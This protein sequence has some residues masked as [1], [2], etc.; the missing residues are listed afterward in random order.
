MRF[1]LYDPYFGSY[2]VVAEVVTWKDGILT[3]T[4]SSSDFN[5]LCSRRFWCSIQFWFWF[6]YSYIDLTKLTP[7]PFSSVPGQG[8]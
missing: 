8:D 6:G 5:L 7:A 1:K 3:L 2:Y 4:T